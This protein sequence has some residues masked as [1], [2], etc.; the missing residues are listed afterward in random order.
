MFSG[1]KIL[2]TICAR[3]GSK[4]IKD[5]NIRDLAGKP[6]IS[7]T[8]TQALRWGKAEYVVVSTDSLRI[9]EVA[10]QF[11]AQVPFMRPSSL[12]GDK[13]PKILAIRQALIESENIFGGKFDIVVDLDVTAPLRRISDL[14]NCLMVFL[15][16]RAKTLF[17]VVKAHRNPYFNMVEEA[18]DGFARLVKSL[19]GGI[20]RRQDAPRVYDMNASIYFYR[21]DFLLRDKS[22]TP[23]S[24]R[25]AIYIMDDLSRYDID[26]DTDLEFVEFLIKEGIWKDEKK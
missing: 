5:K 21:R 22:L 6:L 4:G 12:A 25:T 20:R 1:Q 2:C 26:S 11:G 19:P 13:A 24:D 15:R 9:A 10:R 23:F 18:K 16:R 14:D 7:Y 17:S 8:I 3:G